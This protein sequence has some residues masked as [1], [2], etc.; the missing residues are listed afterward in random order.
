[1]P[2]IHLIPTPSPEEYKYT[3]DEVMEI[4]KKS[5]SNQDKMYEKMQQTMD[6]L[7]HPLHNNIAWISKTM[8]ELQQKLDYT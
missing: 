4:M 6:I 5:M 3:R 1:M 2:G 8:E 7:F